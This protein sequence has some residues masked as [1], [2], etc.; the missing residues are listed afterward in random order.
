MSWELKGVR[1][2]RRS[3]RAGG[4]IEADFTFQPGANGR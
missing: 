4:E 3:G 1:R 2:E